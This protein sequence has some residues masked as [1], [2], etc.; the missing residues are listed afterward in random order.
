MKGFSIKFQEG[1]QGA[2]APLS[3]K[4]M[5][6]V[7]SSAMVEEYDWLSAFPAIRELVDEVQINNLRAHGFTLRN[8]EFESTIGLKVTDILGDRLGLYSRNSQIMGEVARHQPDQLLATLLANGFTTGT[9]YTGS[10]F[11]SA[12]KV[13]YVGATAFTNVTTGRLTAARFATALANM[14][15]RTNPAG[16]PMGLGKNLVLVVSPTY[17]EVARQI[18]FAELISAGNTNVLRNSAKLEVWPEL[19]VNSMEHTWF[20][21]EAGTMMK[22]FMRQ[23]LLPWQYY[24]ITDPKD[25]YVVTKKQFLWQVYGVSNVGYALPELAYGSDGTVA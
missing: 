20:L 23:E 17:E 13:A 3:D 5:D 21:F 16:R 4:L 8:K 7:P 10:A 9:D 1:Y 11:F 18:L 19:S 24:A 22:P 2:A 14:K 15:A 6:T 12:A 25:S